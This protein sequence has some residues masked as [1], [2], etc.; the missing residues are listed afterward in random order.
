MDSRNLLTGFTS[1]SQRLDH[2]HELVKELLGSRN[3]RGPVRQTLTSREDGRKVRILDIGTGN[4]RW[5]VVWW[6]RRFL[7]SCVHRVEEMAE[8]FPHTKVYGLDIGRLPGLHAFAPF[9]I[10]ALVPLATRYPADNVQF[11]VH[12]INLPTRWVRG[13]FD[14]VH[15]RQMC[16]SVGALFSG[17]VQPPY[18]KISSP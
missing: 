6:V 8:E 17:S 11:E 16:F 5:C 1:I 7:Y 14:F 4:G 3:Y 13:R 12:D 2:M 10:C 15:M 9:H 18:L